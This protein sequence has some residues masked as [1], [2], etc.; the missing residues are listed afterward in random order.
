MLNAGAR[1]RADKAARKAEADTLE[2]EYDAMSL[3]IRAIDEAKVAAIEKAKLPVPELSF[4]D[5]DILLD[6]LPFD[7]ASTARKIRVSTALL[8]AL[9]PE[10]RVLLIREGSLLDD[11]ARAALEADAE[12]NNFVVLLETVGDGDGAGGITIVDGEIA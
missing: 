8:M 11:A 7:Q 2:K 6:N 5:E 12:A 4:G 9:K 10:L 3:R 1:K